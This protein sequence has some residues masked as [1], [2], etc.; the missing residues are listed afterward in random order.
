MK[1]LH[2]G[3][4]HLGCKL[5]N[6]SRAEEF[7]RV[8]AYL[9]D[10]V[11]KECVEA[12]LIS[13]DVFDTGAPSSES[14]N[15]YYTFLR[16]LHEAGCKQVVIIA[17]NHDSPAQLK[18][19]ESLLKLSGIH[20]VAQIDR[21][22]PAKEV[23][24]LGDPEHPAAYV[25][26]VPYLRPYE[27]RSA[28]PVEGESAEVRDEAVRNGVQEHYRRVYEL[29]AS[30][31]K[32]PSVPILGM[33][34]LYA[35][36][37]ILGTFK[38]RQQQVGNVQD[39]SLE[40]LADGF[41]YLA[42]GH[43]HRPQA[44]NGHENWRYAGS[45][46][47]MNFR[48]DKEYETQVVLLDTAD[49]STPHINL[50]PREFF[51]PMACLDGTLEELQTQLNDLKK[52]RGDE[53]L[54]VKL[55]CTRRP[56]I[57]D[58]NANL[59]KLVE[60][61]RIQILETELR[62]ASKSDSRDA[63][64]APVSLSEMTP[65]QVFEKYMLKRQ[66]ELPPETLEEYRRL[67]RESQSKAEDP[68]QRQEG[69]AEAPLGRMQFRKLVIKNVN[70]LKEGNIDFQDPAFQDG[71][72]LICGPTGSGKTSIL[73]AIC[74]ALFAETPRVKITNSR[75]DVINLH[76][77]EL[78]AELTFSLGDNEYCATFQHQR[79]K[80]KKD[81]LQNYV[82]T[83]RKNGVEISGKSSETRDQIEELLGMDLGEFTR[84]VLLAQGSFDAFLKSKPKERVEMLRKITGTEH[85][86]EIG[87]K[88][89]EDFLALN[90]QI[91]DLDRLL[92]NQKPLSDEELTK[93]R[94]DLDANEK[95]SQSLDEQLDE[96]KRREGAFERFEKERKT[97]E[98]AQKASETADAAWTAKA[99]EE[100]RLQDARRAQLCQD[101]YD[102]WHN[103]VEQRKKEESRAEGL[104]KER[105]KLEKELP[106]LK[107]NAEEAQ[108]ALEDFQG[109]QCEKESLYLEVHSLDSSINDKSQTLRNEEKDEKKLQS[110]LEKC[111]RDSQTEKDAWE[112]RARQ[113]ED[114]QK[115]LAGHAGDE[116]LATRKGEWD[117]RRKEV[118]R[119]E[120]DAAKKREALTIEED[121][122]RKCE[123]QEKALREK[124]A[125]LQAQVTSCQEELS[126][127]QTR[128]SELLNGHTEEELQNNLGAA[129]KLED[130]F[131]DGAKREAFLTPGAPCP[132]CG[133]TSHPYCEGTPAPQQQAQ[134]LVQALQKTVNALEETKKAL[135]GADKKLDKLQNDQELQKS[136][137]EHLV[138][139]KEEALRR[140]NS[141]VQDWKDAQ[142]DAENKAQSLAE[143]L[144]TLLQ[145]EWTD[146]KSLPKPL[147][148]R[149]AKYQDSRKAVETLERERQE[150]LQKETA[151][152]TQSESLKTQLSAQQAKTASL[153]EELS[154]LRK[155]RQEKLGDQL[156]ET[157]ENALKEEEKK[158]HSALTKASAAQK[159]K[160]AL[161]TSRTKD[162]E[163]LRAKLQ[164]DAAT[165]EAL[166]AKWEESRVQNGFED[167]E[168]FLALRMDPREFQ[169]MDA[170]LNKLKADAEKAKNTLVQQ[171]RHVQEIQK[172]L[173]QDM[174]R[175]ENLARKEQLVAN[176]K[177]LQEQFTDLK[178]KL[179]KDDDLRKDQAKAL[180][181]REKLRPDFEKRKTLDD[182]FG[183]TDHRDNFGKVAQAYTFQELL[184]YANENRPASFSQHFTLEITPVEDPQND[185]L[186]L[187]VIDHYQGDL[188]RTANNLSGGERFEISLAL[189]LGLAA[190]S[191]KSKR[192]S[193]GNV[194][195]DEGF[196]TLDS[197]ELDSAV[198]LLTNINTDDGK[199]VGIISHVEKLQERI[200]TKIQVTSTQ[201]VGK[202][203]IVQTK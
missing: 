33:G 166:R 158:I 41:A 192:I 39:V 17:G 53:D 167:E 31:R 203:E 24:P 172:E 191:A 85:Y 182:Y 6:L 181:D 115:Y 138:S 156:V 49:L 110:A 160:E 199:L 119:L 8:F 195:L 81:A 168:S 55:V 66:P 149:I 108:K 82:H 153:R 68:S 1:L 70:S 116:I 18:A 35:Q 16:D 30:M 201:G 170:T 187:S 159:E 130:F 29:A 171:T 84:C 176:R 61:T 90:E 45:L 103:A 140:R 10:L 99:P 178:G 12:V 114:A 104:D 151:F 89:N 19:P 23:I 72:F 105:Q 174:T 3:D 76:A 190:M 175:E 126:R 142:D 78:L 51:H 64:E 129:K 91:K 135:R 52:T 14:E 100:K 87:R 163:E 111:Q 125:P 47:P 43:I 177:T 46:I 169:E 109:S 118:V 40:T 74:L 122:L 48:E 94:A 194:L 26:A 20:M 189:A 37:S 25:C 60:D 96:A 120:K 155:Q 107:S 92:D 141:V 123:D 147:D 28:T 58:W 127:L 22:D 131:Q 97:L 133:S 162:L 54:W 202:I 185:D 101:D 132:L 9:T 36:G 186:E 144:R 83:L 150:F 102:R 106:Q 34:H 42:L 146:H 95:A 139:Q 62:D 4:I 73:D 79:K 113:A 148:E 180:Q 193:L 188:S 184:H 197:N 198:A 75:N 77:D 27:V 63:E 50:I 2:I 117:A 7:Q 67:F 137:L 164:Q 165:L 44:L 136:D 57:S 11:K 13:G 173:P 161:L 196:G 59:K 157:L 154:N 71:I 69:P 200:R 32:D 88:I 38:G 86:T 134:E 56:E 65:E 21:E 93:I 5:L 15:L 143:E 128:Q 124:A 80:R 152:K 179:Q 98:E 121:S 183:T 145:V 112:E